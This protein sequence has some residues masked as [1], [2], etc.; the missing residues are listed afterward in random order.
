MRKGFIQKQKGFTLIE[1]LV[2]IAIIGLLSSVVLASL[3]TARA[4]ARDSFRISS[5]K[6]LQTALALYANDH[7]G[8]YPQSV[9]S[10]W[11]GPCAASAG[12][13]TGNSNTNASGWIPNLAPTYIV[14]L[15]VDP[16]PPRT[17]ACYLYNSNGTDYTILAWFT[18]ETYSGA[19]NNPLPRTAYPTEPD[20]AVYSS[21]QSVQ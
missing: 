18:A 21:S 5:L 10:Y 14:S 17:T 7:N 13:G 11:E 8:S 6:E 20:F 1:L 4:K 2:V 9:N 15:P 19:T 12:V 3:N 16:S